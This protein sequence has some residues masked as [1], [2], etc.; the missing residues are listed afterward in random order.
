[1]P[2]EFDMVVVYVMFCLFAIVGVILSIK[3]VQLIKGNKQVEKE[4]AGLQFEKLPMGTVKTLSILPL[5]DF[6]SQTICF[7]HAV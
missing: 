5:A 7:A 3:L 2:E 6:F 4:L 1:M